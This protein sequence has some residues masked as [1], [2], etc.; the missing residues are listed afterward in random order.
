[1]FCNQCEQAYKATGC[2]IN[3][4][5]CGKDEDIQSLQEM[6]LYGVK[7]MCAYAHH[8]RRLGQTDA[9]VDEFVERALFS[10]MTNVNFSLQDMLKLVLECGEKNLKVMEMLDR[11][12]VETYGQPEPVEVVEG[13]VAGP[14]MVVTGHDL[15][16]LEQVLEACEGTEVKVYT[17]GEMLPAH[18]YPKL[19]NH[20]NLQGHY[21]TAWQN[22]RYEFSTFPGAIVANTNCIQIPKPGYRERFYTVPPVAAPDGKV[23]EN[24]DFSVLVQAALAAEPCVEQDK[25]FQ[26]IGFHHSV[27]A[28]KAGDIVN[29]VK[30][31]QISRFFVIGGCD[32]A[33]PG[34]N[35]FSDYSQ[36]VPENAFILTLGCGKYRIREHDFGTHLGLPRLMDMGQCNDAY[37]AIRIAG[38]LAEAFECSVNDLPLTL[39]ISWFEQKAVA[40]LLTLLHLGI[41]GI[42]IGPN[43]PAWVTENVFTVLQDTFD[44]KLIGEDAK[45]DVAEACA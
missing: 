21:G 45:A 9:S 40:V 2:N 25:K 20:P 37:G 11:G 41:K 31:G 19:H 15:R 8:A 7:G 6:L 16:M 22:Q 1:M 3:P 39:C 27:I 28:Q 12:H 24:D 44:L 35:Y 30:A 32:G 10:T 14:G 36:A 18:M 42:A 23:I 4:G 17:H 29:A 38:A 33:E 26:T 13:T 43:P 5:I 34:R